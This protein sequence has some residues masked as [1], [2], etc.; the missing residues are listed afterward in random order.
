MFPRC[1]TLYFSLIE[2]KQS[3]LFQPL[4]LVEQPLALLY[5]MYNYRCQTLHLCFWGHLSVLVSCCPCVCFF[6]VSPQVPSVHF[7]MNLTVLWDG[8]LVLFSTNSLCGLNDNHRNNYSLSVSC[9]PGPL[10][11]T[12]YASSH[13]IYP[14]DPMRWIL[15]SPC[16]IEEEVEN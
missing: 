11:S 13:S 15:L 16:F 10:Q 8:G 2:H 3:P 5:L 4:C 7:T 6:A 12:L 14:S 1:S 9:V